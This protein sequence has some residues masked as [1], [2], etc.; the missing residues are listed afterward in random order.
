MKCRKI[1]IGQDLS[2]DD[3]N[4]GLG[5]VY[6]AGP[7]KPKGKSWRL[8]II[9][10]FEDTKIPMCLFVPETN[11]QL[12]GGFSK[13]HQFDRFKWQNF[14]MSVASVLVF[15]F[16]ADCHD[17]Q[18]YVEFGAWHKT[19]RVFLGRE[20]GNVNQYLDWLLYKE[21]KLYPAS[22]MDQLVEMVAHWMKE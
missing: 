9:K 21:H 18:S 22:D 2:Q 10:K 4:Y 3:W 16:P 11:N 1:Y 15:W 5:S 8:D 19:E 20:D 17:Q 6:L 12:K 14:A 13:A 7:R